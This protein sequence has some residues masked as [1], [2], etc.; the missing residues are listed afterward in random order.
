MAFKS[1]NPALSGRTFDAVDT[2]SKAMTLP[3]T[4]NKAAMLL[5]ILVAGAG[6]VWNIY[7]QSHRLDDIAPY[8]WGGA[9]GG[10][11]VAVVTIFKKT[12]SP[13]TAPLYALLKGFAIGGISAVSEA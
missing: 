11:G 7:F 8:L 4:T 2:S 12:I 1:G 10:L 13:Y 9:L 5:A 6:W 3:G